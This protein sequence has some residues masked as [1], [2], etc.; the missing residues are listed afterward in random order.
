MNI[1]P[2]LDVGYDPEFLQI[3]EEIQKH[4]TV[5][6]SDDINNKIKFFNDNPDQRENVLLML[7]ELFNIDEWENNTED[8]INKQIKKILT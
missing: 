5:E 1:L 2:F 7:R 4:I 8:M 3:P 6:N